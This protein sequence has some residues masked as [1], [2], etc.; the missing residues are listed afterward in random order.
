MGIILL[1]LSDVWIFEFS[2]AIKVATF[3][4]LRKYLKYF[5]PTQTTVRNLSRA[6]SYFPF[7]SPVYY[8]PRRMFFQDA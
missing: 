8:F 6:L 4:R 2:T 5:T 3:P 1:V 7:L